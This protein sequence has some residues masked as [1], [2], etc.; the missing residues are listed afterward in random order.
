M[1]FRTDEADGAARFARGQEPGDLLHFRFAGQS[2]VFI[3]RAFAYGKANFAF[4]VEVATE[5]FFFRRPKALDD[6]APGASSAQRIGPAGS[7]PFYFERDHNFLFSKRRFALRFVP[8]VSK[9]TT[10]VAARW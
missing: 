4:D 7:S 5:N 9:H 6:V 2:A 1:L 3:K 10:G 8:A